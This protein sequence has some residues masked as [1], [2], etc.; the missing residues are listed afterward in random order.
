MNMCTTTI[1]IQKEDYN[2]FDILNHEYGHYI[3]DELELCRTFS[4]R[5]PH[6]IHEDLSLSYGDETAKQLAFSEGLASYLAFASQNYYYNK[7]SNIDM[8]G[9]YLFFDR[10]RGG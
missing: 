5:M 9:D 8:I 7:Y 2:N 4:Q 6:G 1:K 10:F 3:C